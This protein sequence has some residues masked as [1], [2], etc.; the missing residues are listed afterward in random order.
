M[1]AAFGL[2]VVATLFL[3]C[4]A[5]SHAA[6]NPYNNPGFETGD[7]SG[8]TLNGLANATTAPKFNRYV[9]A[10]AGTFFGLIGSEILGPT[11]LSQQVTLAQGDTLTGWAAWYIESY[12]YLPPPDPDNHDTGAVEIYLDNTLLATPWSSEL[13]VCTDW[14]PW[15]WEAPADSTYRLCYDYQV[16][17]GNFGNHWSALVFDAPLLDPP[18]P[19]STPEPGTM[20]LLLMGLP[21]AGLLLRRRK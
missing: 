2:T 21:M 17:P 1:R 7:L 15:S 14:Q 10:P 18:S 3:L 12:W 13:G 8:W 6:T 16:N 20:A 4:T 11:T 5:L 19:V 9:P